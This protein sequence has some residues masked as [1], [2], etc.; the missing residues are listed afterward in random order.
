MTHF[1]TKPVRSDTVLP[2]I[3]YLSCD[4]E[5]DVL[6]VSLLSHPLK[7]FLLGSTNF[8][9]FIKN[10]LCMGSAVWLVGGNSQNTHVFWNEMF[11]HESEIL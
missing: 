1:E 8:L 6:A 4:P 11:G 2:S 3:S 10:L 5:A 7:K 9:H